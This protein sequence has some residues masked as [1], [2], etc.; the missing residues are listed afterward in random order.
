MASTA[1]LFDLD[2]TL[3]DSRGFFAEAA[4]SAGLDFNQS[5][6]SLKQGKPAAV[7]LREARVSQSKFKYLPTSLRH[8]LLLY[9]ETQRVLRQLQAD[10]L[11][12]GVVTSL[13]GWIA[14]PMLE[15]TGI[16]QFFD[17]IVDWNR[18][19]RIK[20]SPEPILLALKDMK[21][22]PAP[23]VWYVGDSEVDSQSARSAGVSFA[24]ASYGYSPI[25]PIDA[26]VFLRSLDDLLAL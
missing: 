20:P 18:C 14:L 3:W 15:V 4:S 10:A 24:W 22:D 13:P 6:S 21:V 1:F 16:S 9:P 11:P 8:A 2:G 26:N 5:L 19:R 12:M 17:V 25:R 23:H 7:L